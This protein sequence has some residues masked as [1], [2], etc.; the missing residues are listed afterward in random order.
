M[1]GSVSGIEKGGYR[2]LAAPESFAPAPN[3]RVRFSAGRARAASSA[4]DE[5]AGG[6]P[7]YE[8][9][10]DHFIPVSGDPYAAPGMQTSL[11]TTSAED[12]PDARAMPLAFGDWCLGKIVMPGMLEDQRGGLAN[13]VR[14]GS[15]RVVAFDNHFDLGDGG[16][17]LECPIDSK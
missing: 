1:Y 4:R 14:Q 8:S 5:L 15:Q 9:P 11:N 3:A 2:S 13:A 16:V 7:P 17:R 10:E 12:G 6:R